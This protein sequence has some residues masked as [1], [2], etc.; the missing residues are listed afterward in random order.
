M[1]AGAHCAENAAF[2]VS[3]GLVAQHIVSEPTGKRRGGRELRYDNHGNLAVSLNKRTDGGSAPLISGVPGVGSGNMPGV[4]YEIVVVQKTGGPLTKQISLSPDGQLVS[5]GSACVMW[6]GRA[7]RY[8][9]DDLKALADRLL[10]LDNSEALL[11][12]TLREDLPKA[13]NIVTRRRLADLGE[14]APADTIARE[15]RYIAYRAGQPTLALIDFDT[16]GMPASVKAL[17]EELGGFWPALVSVVPELNDTARVERSSTSAGIRRTDTNELLAG[18]Q[19]IHV[20]L[21]L[22]DGADVERFLRTLHERCWLNGLGWHM[23]GAGGQILE[24]SI[25]DRMV[26]A[27]ERLVFEGAPVLAEGLRQSVEERRPKVLYGTSLDTRA[28]CPD[29]RITERSTVDCAKAKSVHAL[30][31]EQ[32]EERERFAKRMVDRFTERTGV[33]STIAMRIIDRQC[34]GVLLPD[35]VLPWDDEAFEGCTVADVLAE[36]ER[37]VGATMADPLEGVDYGRTKA[38]LMRSGGGTPWIHSFAHG[39]KIYELKFDARA[40]DDAIAKAGPEEV[41]GL[42]VKMAVAGDL[43]A[44]EIESLRDKVADKAGV[45][46][47]AVSASLRA[48][49]QKQ[50]VHAGKEAR[51]RRAAERTDLRPQLPAPKPDAPWLPVMGVLNDVLGH[52]GGDE[53]PMR[54]IEGYVTSIRVKRVPGMHLLVADG[55]NGLAGQGMRGD[56]ATAAAPDG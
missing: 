24:R 17:I 19:G 14:Q 15:N 8:Q 55:A 21:S 44:T 12:G 38:M 53:P 4:S 48:A 18:S 11:L 3:R 20:Y 1:T 30:A 39:R 32:A 49:K 34:E 27:A 56:R 43:D 41:I 50:S 28:A 7:E 47:R 25:V 46:K 52:V 40:I 51:E 16:K 9:F 26:Y 31:P 23:V 36:P 54:D 37:F 22:Q 5:D 10:H 35:V 2:V 42:F 45:G 13:V 6:M 29:L 33:S